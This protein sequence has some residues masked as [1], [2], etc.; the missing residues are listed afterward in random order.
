MHRAPYFGTMLPYA[1]AKKVSKIICAKTALHGCKN[2][3]EIG[4]TLF[5]LFIDFYIILMQVGKLQEGKT[6][7][8][9]TNLLSEILSQAQNFFLKF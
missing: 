5:F 3:G 8:I 1:V 9:L 7:G 2:V 6:K 4:P